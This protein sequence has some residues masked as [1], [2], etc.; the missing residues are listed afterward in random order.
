MY[1][2]SVDLNGM[3]AVSE[4][5]KTSALT[6]RSAHAEEKTVST[7]KDGN[8]TDAAF[9]ILTDAAQW[10]IQRAISQLTEE[11]KRVTMYSVALR[12]Q[13]IERASARVTGAP[14]EYS[15]ADEYLGTTIDR[16]TLNDE[17]LLA[18]IEVRNWNYSRLRGKRGYNGP[19]V[20]CAPV[21]PNRQLARTDP[22]GYG[23][24]RAIML[25][26]REWL[27]KYK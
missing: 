27:A 5:G 3:T 4:T 23:R 13:K 20:K 14:K 19:H 10:T 6:F 25:A 16:D 26:Q 17:G 7:F 22:E 21:I 1:A 12:V 8:T 9:I 11:G 15:T 2:V 18:D 24:L